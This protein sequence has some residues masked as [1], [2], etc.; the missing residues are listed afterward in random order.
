MD[1]RMHGWTYAW[2]DVWMDRPLDER[3]DGQMKGWTG[4]LQMTDRW[5]FVTQAALEGSLP[6]EGATKPIQVLPYQSIY[7]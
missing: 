1:R 6:A 5:T 7:S 3:I 2:M 4:G